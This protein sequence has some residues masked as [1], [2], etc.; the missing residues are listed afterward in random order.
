MASHA[1]DRILHVPG[2]DYPDVGGH[3]IA[4]N[5]MTFR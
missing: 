3:W 5:L 2:P 4:S 1:N